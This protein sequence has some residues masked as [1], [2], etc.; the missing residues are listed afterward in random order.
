MAQSFSFRPFIFIFLRHQLLRKSCTSC[1][2]SSK[3]YEVKARH[4]IIT[5][6]V[7]P[8]LNVVNLLHQLDDPPTLIILGLLC[9][10][11]NTY[12]QLLHNDVE[13]FSI[14]SAAI[15]IPIS[16]IYSYLTSLMFLTQNTVSDVKHCC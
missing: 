6:T 2:L 4:N 7:L 15:S 10:T 14:W 5:I 8:L 12:S 1:C 13:R 16:K 3:I 9:L 11:I